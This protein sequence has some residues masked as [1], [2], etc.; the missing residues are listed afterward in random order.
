MKNARN[1]RISDLSDE[2]IATELFTS[3]KA[4]KGLEENI[5]ILKAELIARGH[6]NTVIHT[7]KKGEIVTIGNDIQKATDIE[8]LGEEYVANPKIRD[9]LNAVALSKVLK[10]TV[11]ECEKHGLI[12]AITTKKVNPRVDIKA[13]KKE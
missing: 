13:V 1:V 4:V 3:I 12:D 9:I 8:Y 2:K 7:S 10:I 5:N 6:A 11:G